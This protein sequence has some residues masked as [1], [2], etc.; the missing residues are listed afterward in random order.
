MSLLEIITGAGLSLWL[1][2]SPSE[3]DYWYPTLPYNVVDGDTMDVTI[4]E[5]FRGRRDERLRLVWY[6]ESNG[7]VVGIDT[8]ELRGE[9]R[10][11]GLAAREYVEQWLQGHAGYNTNTRTW[12]G[13][14]IHYFMVR[15]VKDNTTSTDDRDSFGRYLGD[16]RD[17]AGNSLAR[18]LLDTG[19]AV[20][21]NP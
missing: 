10:P 1:L 17:Q 8:P 13:Q 14:Q 2:F 16:V 4:D 21:W 7:M 11:R 5:G 12:A 20:V 19:H 3:P 18:E 15:T 9:S 6:D